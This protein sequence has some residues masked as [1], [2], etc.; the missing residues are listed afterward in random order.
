MLARAC[1]EGVR[2]G[3]VAGG[4]PEGVAAQG[5]PGRGVGLLR[6]AFTLVCEVQGLRAMWSAVVALAASRGGLRG[7]VDSLGSSGV[8]CSYYFCGRT[9]EQVQCAYTEFKLLAIAVDNSRDPIHREI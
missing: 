8:K 9:G 6:A 3:L 7:Q 1:W 5:G 2:L 4:V